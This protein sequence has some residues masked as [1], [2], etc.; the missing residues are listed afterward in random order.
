M[1]QGGSHHFT[2]I[3]V[4]FMVFWPNKTHTHPHTIN[5]HTHK[6]CFLQMD[7]ATHLVVYGGDSDTGRQIAV[8]LT[9]TVGQPT[10]AA[11]NGAGRRR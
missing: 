1:V 3:M 6:F 11:A 5:T 9:A 8:T 10:V 4:A 7:P 2:V